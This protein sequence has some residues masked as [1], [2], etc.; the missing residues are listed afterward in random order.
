MAAEPV[1]VLLVDDD[2]DDYLLTRDML[3]E[4][5][6]M[7]YALEWAAS[8]EAARDAVRRRA[9]DVYLLDY[10]LG[11][12]NGLELVREI[13]AAGAAAPGIL[14]TGQGAHRVDVEAMEAGAADYLVKG[15][16]T[17]TVLERAI[18]YALQRAR[19]QEALATE[20][21]LL[22][23]IIDSVPDAISVKDRDSRFI[24]INRAQ[25]DNL[26]VATLEDAI[27]KTEID[28]YPTTGAADLYGIE[29]TVMETGRS[30]INHLEET[31]GQP[32]RPRWF[33]STRVPLR[34][35]ERIIGLVGIT[36]D[37]TEIRL[38][39]QRAA[40]AE[41]FARAALD[42][43]DEQIAVLDAEGTVVAVNGA[44]RRFAWDSGWQVPEPGVGSNYLA[45]CAAARTHEARHAMAGIQAVIEGRSSA[46]TQEYL[47]ST[48]QGERWYVMR[49]TPFS[50]G[51]PA[52]VVVAHLEITN[53]AL[54]ESALRAS[55]QRYQQVEQHTPIG[56]AVVALDGRWIRV[57]P[58]L[59]ALV[60]YSA[61]ELLSATFQDI[62]HPDDLDADLANVALLLAGAVDS[63]QMEKRYFHKDGQIVWALLSVSLVRDAAG[64]PLY[65]I[66]QVQDI[67]GLKE[68]EVALRHQATHDSLTG[69]PNRPQLHASLESALQAARDTGQTL[70]LLLLDLDR[71]KEVNDALGHQSGDVVLRQVAT[72]LQRALGAT[73][74][75]ARL[76]GDEFAIVLVAT[77]AATARLV[78]ER[79]LHA[80][81]A[82]FPVGQ[83]L[84][85]IGGSMG[86]ALYPEHGDDASTLLQ[87]ADVALY[88]AK[89][90]SSGVE[91]YD[92]VFD[93]HTVRRLEL[94]HDLRQA[95]RGEGLFL[96][97]QPKLDL[98]TGQPRGVEALLRWRHPVHGFIPPVEFIPLAEQTGLIASL[99]E[100]VLLTALGQLGAWRAAGRRIPI[101]INLSAHSLRNPDFAGLVAGH[102]QRYGMPPADLTLEITESSLIGDP[103]RAR[104]VL[105]RLHDLG[106]RL[107][108]DDFGTGYSSLAYLKEL[109]VDEVKVDKSFVLGMGTGDQ[110]DAAIVRAVVAMAH[111]LGLQ[112]VAEGIEDAATYALLQR[113][114]CD[115]AQGYY[116]SRPCPAEQVERWF[117]ED[118]RVRRA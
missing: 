69:L 94:L 29:Q 44:W 70:G 26:G 46:Y 23:T 18:R 24:R 51:G 87:H 106:V 66:S 90:V 111:E 27:G 43:L 6:G 83:H 40:S 80:L 59:C 20:R 31:S 9:H 115:T 54:A 102:L 57:N 7:A 5:E 15:E 61:D 107:A 19:A 74:S 10:H 71:F 35:A 17:A 13:V 68:A 21:D 82:P 88:V 48:P 22:R 67:S 77:D 92:P 28:L 63:Y 14:L 1:R 100:W 116:L 64:V 3:A 12:H 47:C 38:A 79:L 76:G 110:R 105:T 101:A 117:D 75:I 112:V 60:G 2:E 73:E 41:G 65:F 53:R 72:R 45:V 16:I 93:Q 109:P 86:I 91:L 58:A 62:T 108:I 95:V 50:G 33:L 113:L 81:D 4:I 30:L 78:A 37:I 103:A 96:Y 104:E 98:A 114:G 36:R 97:Y 25:A 56:L 84:L 118:A 89:R 52:R 34:R 99:T 42:A 11:A 55:E 32:D 39:E 85:D 49:V 8:Y